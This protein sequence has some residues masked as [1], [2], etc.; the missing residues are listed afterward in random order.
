MKLDKEYLA[1][2]GEYAVA[3]ELCR[4][5]IYVQLTLGNRKRTDLLI[6]TEK[7]ML[8]V[9]VKSKQKKY[10]VL[11]KGVYGSDIA[12]VFVDYQNKE[13]ERKPD[14]YVLTSK[15]WSSFV[16]RGWI[17]DE[18]SEGRFKLDDVNC[19]VRVREDGSTAWKGIDIEASELA[20]YKDGWDKIEARTTS[21]TRE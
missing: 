8:S 4:R 3:S 16:R 19:P 9:Q 7:G 18:V 20:K 2:A 1:L 11:V 15:D 12:L 17:K 14:F 13:L 6:Q 10:W 5:G 21:K